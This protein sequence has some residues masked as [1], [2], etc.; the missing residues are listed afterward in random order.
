MIYIWYLKRIIK[1][2]IFF[3][4]VCNFLKTIHDFITEQALKN[5]LLKAIN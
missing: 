2:L 3:L 4:I 5:Y 1:N